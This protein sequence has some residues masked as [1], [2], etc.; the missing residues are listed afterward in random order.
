MYVEERDGTKGWIS[1]SQLTRARAVLVIGEEPVALREEPI[2]G[3]KLRWRAEPGVVAKLLRCREKWCEVDAA[4]RTGWVKA[5]RLWGDEGP[6]SE[7]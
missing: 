1:E 6:A 5:D 3:S 7:S 4:G 2:G